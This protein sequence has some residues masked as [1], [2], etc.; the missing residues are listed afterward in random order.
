MSFR[1][2][3]GAVGLLKRLLG[4]LA[5]L[6]RAWSEASDSLTQTMQL[7]RDHL[8]VPRPPQEGGPGL[9]VLLPPPATPR[10]QRLRKEVRLRKESR[11]GEIKHK[12]IASQ[13]GGTALVLSTGI[14]I[15]SDI[16]PQS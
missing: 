1:N 15:H 9:E 5:S 2:S 7:F 11:L 8:A 13:E 16:R 14:F 10:W 6:R 3:Q 12:S 4:L